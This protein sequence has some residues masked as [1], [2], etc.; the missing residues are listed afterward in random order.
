MK[1]ERTEL[2]ELV[3]KWV[4][5]AEEDLNFAKHGLNISSGVS[6]RIITFHAQQCVEK[7]LKAFL[8]FHKIDFP[9]THN[10]TTLLDLCSEIDKSA[11]RLRDAEILTGYSTVMRYPGEYE[12][13][14]KKDALNSIKLAEKVRAATRDKFFT[15]GVKLK[16]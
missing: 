1:N 8:V 10:I 12:K 2:A 11:E 15:A 9:Y 7:Y 3:N 14:Q 4:E 16:N 6:Y 13:L 5:I